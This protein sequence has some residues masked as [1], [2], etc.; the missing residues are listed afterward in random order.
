MF[1]IIYIIELIKLMS[2]IVKRI[3]KYMGKTYMHIYTQKYPHDNAIIVSDLASLKKMVDCINQ[4][5]LTNTE[6]KTKVCA[7]DGE[8]Y[9]LWICPVNKID[10]KLELPYK[11]NKYLNSED[12]IKIEDWLR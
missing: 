6:Q 3:I 12:Q 7:V 11:D 1:G 5:I 2:R 4:V 9:M 8:E 10:N